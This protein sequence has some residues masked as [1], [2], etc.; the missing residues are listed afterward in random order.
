MRWGMVI[1]L[2]KCVAC[3]SCTVACKIENNVPFSGA[4]DAESARGI[5]WNEVL[6]E[7]KGEFPNTTVK[8][9]PRPCMHC[10]EAPCVKVCPTKASYKT[11]DGLVLIDY[12]KCIGC[13]YCMSACP[14][15]ARYFNWTEPEFETPLDKALNPDPETKPRPK[16][17]VE[18]CTFCVQR[19]RKAKEKAKAENRPLRDGDVQP[20]CVQT[21]PPGARVFGDL[22]DPDSEVSRLARSPRAFKLHEEKGTKPKVIYLQEG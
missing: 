19:I 7:T 13:R 16:G 17:V 20:A 3:Q 14:Y 1:D 12:N 18:K 8:Y 6:K 15:G 5:F 21:C 4:K 11:E 9:T 22:D 10:E 2:D